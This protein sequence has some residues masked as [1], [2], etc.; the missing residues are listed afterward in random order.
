MRGRL[1]GSGIALPSLT[2]PDGP[3]DSMAPED[4]LNPGIGGGRLALMAFTGS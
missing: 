4:W 1:P 2:A 3:H